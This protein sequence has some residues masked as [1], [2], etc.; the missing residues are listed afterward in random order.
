VL[1]RLPPKGDLGYLAEAEGHM[2]VTRSILLRETT[3]PSTSYVERV[4]RTRKRG[5][6]NRRGSARGEV[7]PRT[8]SCNLYPRASLAT[9]LPR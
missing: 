6:E 4:A 9:R 7:V 3:G 1:N 5:N 8:D 2:E